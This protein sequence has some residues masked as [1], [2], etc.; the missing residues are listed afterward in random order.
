[1][2][3]VAGI[4]TEEEEQDPSPSCWST[5]RRRAT[6]CRKASGWVAVDPLQRD[7]NQRS[8]NSESLP[9]TVT[10]ADGDDLDE[11]RVERTFV[12]QLKSVHAERYADT[13]TVQQLEPMTRSVYGHMRFVSPVGLTTC[14]DPVSGT[15]TLLALASPETFTLW[16]TQDHWPH[17][18][19]AM[20]GNYY[21][22]TLVAE[23]PVH[24]KTARAGLTSLGLGVSTK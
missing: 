17:M 6:C 16:V 14:H 5:L 12:I 1:M 2:N 4:M 24:C 9:S 15:I 7:R 3:L 8:L 21:R 13:L 22:I 10:R 20:L 11:F 19:T 23:V 18:Q